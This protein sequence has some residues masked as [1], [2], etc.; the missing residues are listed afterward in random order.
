MQV[1]NIRLRV[2]VR[3]TRRNEDLESL[4][5]CTYIY[6]GLYSVVMLSMHAHTGS[7][8]LCL[9]AYSVHGMHGICSMLLKL[10]TSCCTIPTA[11]SSYSCIVCSKLDTEYLYNFC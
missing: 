1:N 7:Q 9:Y 11:A 2:P 4:Y 5:G 10:K 6:D 3:V 8:T